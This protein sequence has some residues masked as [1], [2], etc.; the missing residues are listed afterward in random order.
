MACNSSGGKGG[1]GGGGGKSESAIDEKQIRAKL[2]DMKTEELIANPN[3]ENFMSLK[4][5][6]NNVLNDIYSPHAGESS[7]LWDY[8]DGGYRSLNEYLRDPNPTIRL[9]AKVIKKVQ[10]AQ[11]EI[12]EHFASAK[13]LDFDIT[14]YRGIIGGTL[15]DHK[16]GDVRSDKGYMS[17]SLN[18]IQSLAF[19]N[20]AQKSPGGNYESTPAYILKLKVKKG[21][22]VLNV[23]NDVES[24][25]LL[26]R[27]TKYKI[28][29]VRKPD[30]N[31][32][33]IIEGE[34]LND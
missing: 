17:T 6:A 12:D 24:E 8:T 29:K 26:N 15:K 34:V 1:A 7:Y 33:A 21:T 30:A 5:D 23:D 10:A 14:V 3:Q 13:G 20:K 25:V 31:G 2:L 19:S 11:K 27:N 18:G 22:K 32:T 28:T 4:R 9:K 16:A